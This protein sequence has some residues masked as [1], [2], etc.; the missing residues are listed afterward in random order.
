MVYRSWH[1][2]EPARI[3]SLISLRKLHNH[4]EVNQGVALAYRWLYLFVFRVRPTQFQDS[5]A[6]TGRNPFTDSHAISTLTN[7]SVDNLDRVE[8]STYRE[9]A[10]NGRL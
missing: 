8:M 5:V 3:L 4:M 6:S 10:T 2:T 7:V 1:L 9:E